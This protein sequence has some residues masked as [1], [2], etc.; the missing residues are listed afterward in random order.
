[1][2]SEDVW[3]A[4]IFSECGEST[5][6][7]GLKCRIGVAMNSGTSTDSEEE[8]DAGEEMLFGLAFGS[9][10]GEATDQIDSTTTISTEKRSS[11]TTPLAREIVP[12]LSGNAN[13]VMCYRALVAELYQY[14]D[15]LPL[16]ETNDFQDLF[17]WAISRGANLDGITYANDNH[18]GRCLTATSHSCEGSAVAT[19][20]RSLRIGQS[21]ACKVLNLPK[22]TPDLSALTLLVL[23][24]SR[25]SHPYA[26]CLPR[27]HQFS[28]GILMSTADAQAWGSIGDSYAT[29]INSVRSVRDGCQSYVRDVL[30]P[31]GCLHGP[32]DSFPWAVSMVK[33]RSHAFGSKKGF[34]LT[35]VFDLVNHSLTPNS[36]LVTG[37]GGQLILQ[38]LSPIAC[39]DEITID[40]QVEDDSKLLAVYGF[41]LQHK[42]VPR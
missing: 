33:S 27:K 29:A 28:N 19:L 4:T 37:D 30:A 39:G 14:E 38:T 10:G 35:P 25:N 11:A 17:E 36:K 24:F 42:T 2:R 34:W 41:S 16:A 6:D 32:S 26:R 20:P 40:Y 18:K 8:R 9:L 7:I 22:N 5:S 3:L 13:S 23:H 21:Y 15:N 1:M 31:P 12:I